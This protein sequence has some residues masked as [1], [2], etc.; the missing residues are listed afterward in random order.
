M[1]VGDRVSWADARGNVRFGV[2]DEIDDDDSMHPGRVYIAEAMT[3]TR[4][5][6]RPRITTSWFDAHE[7]HRLTRRPD[8]DVRDK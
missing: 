7:A 6:R 3:N 8:D 4:G 1:K 2:V 5:R